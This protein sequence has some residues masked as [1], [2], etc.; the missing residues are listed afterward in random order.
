MSADYHRAAELI[1]DALDAADEGYHDRET[2]TVDT[3]SGQ[4]AVALLDAGWQPASGGS[5]RVGDTLHGFCGGAF[6]RESYGDK[7]VEAVGTD[8][9]VAREADTN[10]AQFYWG[11]PQQ[12]EEYR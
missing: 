10:E 5:L 3:T 7:T 2:G 9:V 11:G 4:I 8:W 6:G 12:L 1:H